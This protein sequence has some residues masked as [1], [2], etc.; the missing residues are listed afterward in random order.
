[1]HA[2]FVFD[3]L[4]FLFD[5]AGE[6]LNARSPFSSSFKPALPAV[7]PPHRRRALCHGVFAARCQR[8]QEDPDF[9]ED[10]G[11]RRFEALVVFI[12]IFS[13]GRRAAHSRQSRAL[14]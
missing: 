1:M 11:Q 14:C 12:F 3:T 2:F 13:R 6:T 10:F 5:A 7:L 8:S 9:Q 4:R